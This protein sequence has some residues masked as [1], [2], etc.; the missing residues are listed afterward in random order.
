MTFTCGRSLKRIVFGGLKS[1]VPFSDVIFADILTSFS[2]VFGDLEFALGDLL[3]PTH[4]HERLRFSWLSWVAPVI[5]CLPYCFRFRQ[6]LSEY[7][8]CS[9]SEKNRHLANALKYLSVFPVIFSIAYYNWIRKWNDELGVQDIFDNIKT[10]TV[11]STVS[12]WIF[13]SVIHSAYSLY[14]DIFVD[15]ELFGKGSSSILGRPLYFKNP[16][17]YVLAILFNIVIRFFWMRKVASLHDATV[18]VW[19]EYEFKILEIIRRWIWVFFR[20]EREWLMQDGTKV[21]MSDLME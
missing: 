4:V 17:F 21:E 13:F 18:I 16:L 1:T 19:Y 2:R 20:V 7:F 5:L 3:L 9:R 8:L 12:V 11:R 14:W 6:C 15:W 10:D